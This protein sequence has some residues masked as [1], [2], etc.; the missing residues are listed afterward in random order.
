[1]SGGVA[2]E[3]VDEAKDAVGDEVEVEVLVGEKVVAAHGEEDGRDGEIE[4]EFGDGG[5]PA[6]H[7]RGILNRVPLGGACDAEAAA[8]SETADAARGDAEGDGD[9]EGVAGWFF[10]ARHPLGGYQ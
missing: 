9:G 3:F 2:R 6:I 7:S 1:M 10:V 8:V 4:D 5:G